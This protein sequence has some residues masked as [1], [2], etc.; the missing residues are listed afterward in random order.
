MVSVI[1]WMSGHGRLGSIAWISRRML[2]TSDAGAT[3]PA[4]RASC[5]FR[6][7]ARP[8][9]RRPAARLRRARRTCCRGRRRRSRTTALAR[10]ADALADGL[11]AREVHLRHRLVDDDDRR[12]ALDVPIVESRPATSG[13]P[14]VWKKPGPMTFA[15]T[16][17]GSLATPHHRPRSSGDCRGPPGLRRAG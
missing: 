16:R 9:N 2:A 3:E 5:P 1:G 11:A 13:M 12:S 8:A 6:D 10:E 7:S 15:L 14:S 17:V 4:R